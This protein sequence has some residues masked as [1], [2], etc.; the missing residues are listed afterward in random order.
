[1]SNM[2]VT[3]TPL[4]VSTRYRGEQEVSFRFCGNF[5]KNWLLSRTSFRRPVKSGRT[6]QPRA[7]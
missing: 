4:P 1:M 3:G 7:Q 6:N 5:G 2:T